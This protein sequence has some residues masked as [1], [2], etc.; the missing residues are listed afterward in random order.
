M[1]CP[2]AEALFAADQTVV[3]SH[4]P[5]CYRRYYH[6]IQHAIL[7]VYDRHAG[8]GLVLYLVPV[9]GPPASAS[10][11]RTLGVG[12]ESIKKAAGP[13]IDCSIEYRY[14]MMRMDK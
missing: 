10:C 8:G 1:V 11:C 7:A 3:S 6:E 4:L 13:S 14:M 5:L 9:S 2:Q 12:V